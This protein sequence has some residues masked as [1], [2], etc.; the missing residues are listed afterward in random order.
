MV[1]AM[2]IRHHAAA[3]G[4]LCD[5]PA[6]GVLLGEPQGLSAAQLGAAR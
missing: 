6:A 2:L 5:Q 1:L 3:G 4:R